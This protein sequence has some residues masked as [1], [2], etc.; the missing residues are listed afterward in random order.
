MVRV[1]GEAP[2]GAK[3]VDVDEGGNGTTDYQR[4]YQMIRQAAPIG[5]L[6]FE[7]EFLDAGVEAFVFTFG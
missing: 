4:M 5:D 2:G 7:I 3:G 1:D 6:R